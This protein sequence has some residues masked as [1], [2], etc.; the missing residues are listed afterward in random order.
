MLSLPCPAL[1]FAAEGQAADSIVPSRSPN[2]PETRRTATRKCGIQLLLCAEPQ[3]GEA[4]N[5]S[6]P[7]GGSPQSCCYEAGLRLGQVGP[8]PDLGPGLWTTG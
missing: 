1:P 8:K 5:W 2:L 7:G 4:G 3:L 6:S